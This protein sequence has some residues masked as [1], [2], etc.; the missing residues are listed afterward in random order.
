M[1]FSI[2]WEKAYQSGAQLSQ[3]PWSDLVSYVMRFSR[4]QG[5]DYSVLELGCGPG[6]NIPFFTSLGVKYFAVEGSATMVSRL[7]EKHPQLR[8][9]IVQGD[10]TRDIP[11]QHQFDL[12]VDRG[13]L[14]HN[15]E[16]GIQSALNLA[17]D[18][19]KKGGNFIG[20]DWFS[21]LSS[22]YHAGAPAEDLWTK[23]N[24]ES[25]RVAGLGRVH[26][27][28][29]V[30]LRSLFLKFDLKVL[31]QKII[32]CELPNPNYREAFWNLVAYKK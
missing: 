14:T 15:C 24:I 10:F 19:L 11:F 9:T 31:E 8:E 28:D 25:G 30:H 1:G 29:Q 23:S 22:E 21:T 32:L 16:S 13:S 17:Y 5:S 3:W 2:E 20:I 12:I 6:A 7:H 18:H 26:F 27:S 4:P